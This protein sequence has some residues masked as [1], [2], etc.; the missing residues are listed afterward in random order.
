MIIAGGAE[1]LARSGGTADVAAFDLYLRGKQLFDSQKDE[2]SD[3]EALGQFTRAVQL[4]PA[5]AAARAARSR[6]LAVIVIGSA[7]TTA[8]AL[9][10]LW[11]AF[12]TKSDDVPS[13]RGRSLRS[14]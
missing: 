12:A 13:A 8:Y 6:A 9:R 4:D 7:F 10:L 2:A 11:G 3:R 14:R 5:Y 1:S